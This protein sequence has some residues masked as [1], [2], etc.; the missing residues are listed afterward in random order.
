MKYTHLTKKG[1]GRLLKAGLKCFIHYQKGW[2][3]SIILEDGT[4]WAGSLEDLEE[5]K[6]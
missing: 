3:V 1:F 6:G 2:S 5:I 4:V